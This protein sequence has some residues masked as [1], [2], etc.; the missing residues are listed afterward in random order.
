MKKNNNSWKIIW[1]IIPPEFRKMAL[2]F[3][4]MSG[5]AMLLEMLTLAL[6]VPLLSSVSSHPQATLDGNFYWLSYL[7]RLDF[8]NPVEILLLLVVTYF[9]KNAYLLILAKYQGLFIFGL[10]EDL[11]I[12]L[13]NSYIHRPY[14]QLAETNSA[15]IIRSVVQD[16]A[17]FAHNG[18]AP[19]CNLITEIFISFGILALLMW[20]N[21]QATFSIIFLL[22][23]VGYI[24]FSGVKAF[25]E[26]LGKNRQIQEGNRIKK[27]QEGIGAIKEIKVGGLEDYFSHIYSEHTNSSLLSGRQQQFLQATPRLVLEFL[28]ILFL[29]FLAYF[30]H[31][32]DDEVIPLLG[33]YVA[34]SFRLMPSVNRIMG[35]LQSIK[36]ADSSMALLLKEV[37][38][39]LN[40]ITSTSGVIESSNKVEVNN[41]SF[42]Y[43][44]ENSPVISNGNFS[45]NRGD[46]IFVT[47]K[48]GSGKTTLVDILCGLI[49]PK[50][51]S[52]VVDGVDMALSRK[53]WQERIAYVPQSTFLIEGT[54]KDNIIFGTQDNKINQDRLSLALS[55]TGLD[56]LVS[57]HPQGLNMVVGE[58][59]G[60]LSGGQRQRVGLARAIY[61]NRPFLILD[62][63]TNAIDESSE[64]KIF[65]RLF[66]TMSGVT[67][68]WI[69]HSKLPMSY[70]NAILRLEDGSVSLNHIK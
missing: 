66:D 61:K 18:V 43:E 12:R 59:G 36:Y 5:F 51:G 48:S 63:A 4:I 37:E 62:E 47:G 15:K 55:L 65:D 28:T 30:L 7:L 53:S 50:S 56:A 64:A 14:L 27:I 25:I 9:L 35:S 11:S 69:S 19:F 6:I 40:K 23:G 52:I 67:V 13:F 33:L 29:M 20:A 10:E 32:S 22:G 45:I 44:S 24:F 34:A 58:R 68:I 17:N 38:R 3:I 60:T 54:L 57:A 26:K 16:V 8:S 21:P 1:K 39:P 49:S 2:I 31:R 42:S 70:A 46:I 41:L